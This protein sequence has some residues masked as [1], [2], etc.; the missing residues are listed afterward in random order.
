MENGYYKMNFISKA[1]LKIYAKMAILFQM[2]IGLQVYSQGRQKMT[3][4]IHLMKGSSYNRAPSQDTTRQYTCGDRVNAVNARVQS[5]DND[6][7]GNFAIGNYWNHWRPENPEH[8]F[9]SKWHHWLNQC[10]I[11]KANGNIGKASGTIGNPL[12]P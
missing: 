4:L 5:F 3:Q 2:V 6:T 9:S 1:L 7:N 12:A 11:G 8:F 10:T